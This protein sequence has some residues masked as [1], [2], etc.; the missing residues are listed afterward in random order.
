[1]REDPGAIEVLL[2]VA[3]FVLPAILCIYGAAEGGRRPHSR[4][5]RAWELSPPRDDP[6]TAR[7]RDSAEGRQAG[8]PDP[9]QAIRNHSLFDRELDY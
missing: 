9:L 7:R 3:L 6:R 1:M 2:Y 4:S 8:I 5:R